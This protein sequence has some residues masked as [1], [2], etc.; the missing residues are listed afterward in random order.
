VTHLTLELVTPD[1]PRVAREWRAL[2]Q[3]AAPTYFSSW[4]FV[5][6]WL[7]ALPASVRPRLALVKKSGTTCSAFFLGRARVVRHHL[8][9]SRALYFNATGTPEYDELCIEHNALLTDPSAGCSLSDLVELLPD[10]WDEIFLPALSADRE[11]GCSGADHVAGFTVV[12]DR[13]ARCPFVDLERVRRSPEGYVGL[14]GANVRAQIRRA[15]RGFGDVH[16][17]VA[18][19][20]PRALEY[21]DELV[22]LHTAHWT[23]HGLAG[24]FADPW[25]ERFHRTLIEKRLSSGEI[26]LLRVRA[27]S[28]TLACL[29]NFSFRGRVLFY[30]SGIARFDDPRLKPGYVAHAEAI[31]LN[32]ELGHSVY[33]FLGGDSRYKRSLSTGESELVWLRVQRPLVRF[34]VERELALFKRALLG[35]RVT[36][37]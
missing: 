9:P 23:A 3:R 7:S 30:Q 24:A 22:A 11:P 4:G 36:T 15:R 35:A 1:S 18:R 20:L 12:V 28:T 25:F 32:A 10:D 13:R 2:E 34:A 26:Q 21:W 27:G 29:Y 31:A 14:L 8:F 6:H 16:V 17:E 5:E 19:E 33:D 37:S